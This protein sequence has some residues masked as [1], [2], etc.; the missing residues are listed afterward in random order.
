[1]ILEDDIYGKFEITEQVI[2]DLL[3]SP[4]MERLKGISN[5]GFYPGGY[6]KAQDEKIN[7][8]NHSVGVFLLLRKFDAPLEEQIAGLIH[9]I[10]HSAF[11]HTIDHVFPEDKEYQKNNDSQDDIH[12]SFISKTDIPEILAKHNID[13]SYVIN[14]KNFPLEE[15]DLPDICADRIDYSLRQSLADGTLSVQNK[16]I[17]LNGLITSDGVF[18]FK[19]ESS[20]QLFTENFWRQDDVDWTNKKTV[21]M[22]HYNGKLLKKMVDKGYLLKSDLFVKNDKEIINMFH[23]KSKEDNDIKGVLDILYLPTD[24]FDFSMHGPED[25]LYLKVRKVDPLVLVGNNLKRYSD[26]SAEYA[27]RYSKAPKYIERYLS[28]KD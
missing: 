19:D 26:L 22:F 3:V 17:I 14:E 16:D 9:D 25:H 13:L 21:V 20:A 4:F 6:A 7:R 1:M 18:C 24:A 28:L 23:K 12:E 15:R 10:S 2:I 27:E 8:Y 5:I 11:S